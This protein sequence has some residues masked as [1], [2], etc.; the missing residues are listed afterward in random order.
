MGVRGAAPLDGSLHSAR[1]VKALL[2]DKSTAV[3]RPSINEQ[4]AI[5]TIVISAMYLLGRPSAKVQG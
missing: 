1:Q 4:V 3:K 2:A 5:A